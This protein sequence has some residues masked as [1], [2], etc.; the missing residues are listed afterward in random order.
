MKPYII[1]IWNGIKTVSIAVWNG[2]K[3]G[4]ATWNGIKF[5]ILHPIQALKNAI[6]MERH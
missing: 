6:N 2:L 3:M 5:A 4:V 1:G